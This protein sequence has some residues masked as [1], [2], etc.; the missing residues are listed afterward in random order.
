MAGGAWD[1][2][3]YARF[4]DERRQP[5]LDL[6]ALVQSRPGMRVVDLGC[7]TGE[8]TRVVH[9]RLAARDTL[10][11]DSSA[12]MLAESGAFAAPGL[13]FLQ[14]TIEQFAAPNRVDLVFSNA[15]LHWVPD[16]PALL[17]RLAGALA[18]G[19]Q[20]AVQIPANFD[21]P[22]HTT[23][24]AVAAEEPFRTALAGGTHPAG[25][26]APD[27]Y[28]ALLARLGFRQQHVRLQVYGHWLRARDDVVEWTKGTLLTDYRRRLAPILYEQLVARYRQLLLPQLEDTQPYFFPFKRILFW[29]RR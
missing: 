19:G 1:P 2:E 6:L 17:A 11:L 22:S 18:D 7:G 23:A 28:A 27:A 12:T 3:Q 10:G 20:L 16:H 26:L 9:E 21:H 13:R 14:G 8:L 4:A 24:F 29:A 5:F 15:A 25:V